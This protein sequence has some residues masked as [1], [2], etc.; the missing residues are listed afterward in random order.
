[1]LDEHQN[2]NFK[3]IP[4]QNHAFRS[5]L[6]VVADVGA[7]SMTPQTLQSFFSSGIRSG[8]IQWSLDQASA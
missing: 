1:M 4:D 8:L 3:H 5:E 6:N 7:T 2:A